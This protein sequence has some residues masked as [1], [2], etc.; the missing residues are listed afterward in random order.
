LQYR[1]GRPIEHARGPRDIENRNAHA[2]ASLP[3]NDRDR[4]I[5]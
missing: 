1:F 4:M 3:A 5:R 2:V